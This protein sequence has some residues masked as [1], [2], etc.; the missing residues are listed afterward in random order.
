VCRPRQVVSGEG[1][2]QRGDASD[3]KANAHRSASVYLASASA[4][5]VEIHSGFGCKASA[6]RNIRFAAQIYPISDD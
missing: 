4:H 3:E 2:L 6:V 5:A 1:R